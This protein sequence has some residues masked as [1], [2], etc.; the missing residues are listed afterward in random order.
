VVADQAVHQQVGVLAVE[1]GGVDLQGGQEGLEGGVR[2]RKDGGAG[3]GGV[4]E[5]VEAGNLGGAGEDAQVLVTLEGLW[6]EEVRSCRAVGG[7][8]E[9]EGWGWG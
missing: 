3:H 8:G 9:E 7:R 2:G 1:G 5:G 6:L 4:Q